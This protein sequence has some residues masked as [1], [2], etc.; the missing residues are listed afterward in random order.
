MLT[1]YAQEKETPLPRHLLTNQGIVALAEAGYDEDFLI[2]L[3]QCK[4]TRF[5]TTVEGL[6]F[7]AKHGISERIVRVMIDNEKKP[8]SG[9]SIAPP[10]PAHVAPAQVVAATMVAGSQVQAVSVPPTPAPS[11][12]YVVVKRHWFRSRW[13]IVNPPPPPYAPLQ[14]SLFSGW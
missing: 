11:A 14:S 1:L 12:P 10:Q 5:D 6:A 7:L 4:E 2:D 9:A 8:A 3:I 13:Y